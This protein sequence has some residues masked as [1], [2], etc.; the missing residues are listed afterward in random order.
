LL[1][2]ELRVLLFVFS[3]LCV[4]ATA[5]FFLVAAVYRRVNRREEKLSQQYR[6]ARK[7]SFA[8]AEL[9][10]LCIGYSFYE[11]SR[12]EVTHVKISSPKLAKTAGSIRIVHISDLHSDPKPRLEN[13]LATIIAA[14]RPDLIVFTGD[15]V[16]SVAGIPVFRRVMGDF[17]R[18]APTFVVKGNWDQWSGSSEQL[19]NGTGVVH[20]DGNSVR[21]EFRGI[22]VWISGMDYGSSAN[23]ANAL[24]RIPL[25]EF[26]LFL[27]HLPDEIFEIADQSVDLYCAGHTHG[28]Q[29]ALPLYGALITFSRF[30][31]QFEWGLHKVKNTW[32]YVN[33]GIGMEGGAAPRVRF[34]ARPEITVIDIVPAN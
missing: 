18:I 23:L 27:Y 29:V 11:P 14:E 6:L 33:R 24:G 20:V 21:R 16:N 31:K 4:F 26:S 12:A 2:Q 3:V 25:N 32:L 9:G 22:P 7:I 5:A 17:A 19:F 13:N 10:I 1:S 15:S 34:W 8:L 28:G 30:D